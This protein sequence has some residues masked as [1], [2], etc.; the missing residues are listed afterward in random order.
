MAHTQINKDLCSKYLPVFTLDEFKSIERTFNKYKGE[1]HH[2]TLEQ[3]QDHLTQKDAGLNMLKTKSLIEKA[4]AKDHNKVNLESFV[5]FK[6]LVAGKENELSIVDKDDLTSFENKLTEE[7][8]VPQE[9]ATSMK[10]KLAFF[11]N[12]QT[13]E[14]EKKKVIDEHIRL[15]TEKDERDAAVKKELKKK[16][17]EK[18]KQKED[19]AKAS[20]SAISSKKWGQ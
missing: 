17:K 18:A 9:G 20:K 4:G 12:Q 11:K 16:E 19:E 8:E 1:G 15:K 7:K 3:I 5:R 6:A 2:I 13:A 10:D 14:E